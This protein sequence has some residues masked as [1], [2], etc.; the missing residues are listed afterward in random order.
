MRCEGFPLWSDVPQVSNIV[1]YVGL[2]CFQGTHSVGDSTIYWS[3]HFLNTTRFTTLAI[4]S[5]RWLKVEHSRK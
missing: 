3:S 4:M 1:R 5:Q 2:V